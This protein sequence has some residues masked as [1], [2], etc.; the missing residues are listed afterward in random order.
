MEFSVVMHTGLRIKLVRMAR[1]LTQSDLADKINKTR[2]LIS[3]IEQTGKVHPYTL[4]LILDALDIDEE[5]LLQV[6][7][8]YIPYV[9]RN[10]KTPE[11]TQ[12]EEMDQMKK[13]IELLERENEAL[14]R[15]VDT[16]DDMIRDLRKRDR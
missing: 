11:N 3:H 7:E 4:R 14:R 10:T 2:P 1:G 16:Q 12:K 5:T 6:N 13:I 15:L 9:S 8:N